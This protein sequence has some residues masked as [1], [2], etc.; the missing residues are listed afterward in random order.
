MGGHWGADLIHLSLPVSFRGILA[1]Y[2]LDCSFDSVIA[3]EG[4]DGVG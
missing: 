2:R 1:S 3:V 4:G